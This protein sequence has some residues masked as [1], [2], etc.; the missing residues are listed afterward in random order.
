MTRDAVRA[1][2]S[3]T[4]IDLFAE[5]GFDEVT[6]EQVAAEVG[7]STRSFNRYFPAKEDAVIGDT[8]AWGEH[9]R[10]ALVAR[11]LDEPVW[12]SLRHSFLSLLALS[13]AHD[14][15][16]K[17]A[18]RVLGSTPSLRARNLEKHLQWEQLL[19]PVV[20]SRSRGDDAEVRARAIVQSSLACFDVAIAT[21][22]RRDETRSPAQLVT[23]CFAALR[24][25]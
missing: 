15:R 6:V 8:A 23:A 5:H 4:A 9:V 10:E 21:W 19:S 13:D 24:D 7:I 20:A 11:P 17:R 22:A 25:S 12:D 14:D 3:A 18:I 1:R 2:I 16:Q